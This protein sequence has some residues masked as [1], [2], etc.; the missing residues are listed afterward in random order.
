M[1][2]HPS[3]NSRGRPWMTTFLATTTT[4]AM[5]TATQTTNQIPIGCWQTNRFT[6]TPSISKLPTNS[7]SLGDLANNLF[8][9]ASFSRAASTH[10]TSNNSS[11][12][13]WQLRGAR[14]TIWPA[15]PSIATSSKRSLVRVRPGKV[16]LRR[17]GGILSS[18]L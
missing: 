1:Q 5:T 9:R 12:P 16:M 11:N 14:P 6:R 7:T 18:L 4:L 2:L 10:C 17:I 13:Q 3:R 15:S 8:V